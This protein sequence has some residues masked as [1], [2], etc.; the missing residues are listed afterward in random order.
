MSQEI[1]EFVLEIEGLHSEI[2]SLRAENGRLIMANKA[3]NAEMHRQVA[4]ARTQHMADLRDMSREA[5]ADAEEAAYKC[6][7]WVDW[8]DQ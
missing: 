7:D 8:L 2:I 5:I 4:D 3:L 1:D 6:V